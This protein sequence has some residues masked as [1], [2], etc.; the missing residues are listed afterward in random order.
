MIFGGTCELWSGGIRAGSRRRRRQAVTVQAVSLKF[1]DSTALFL[2]FLEGEE[3]KRRK[4][5][6]G[7]A[8]CRSGRGGPQEGP[9][10]QRP[11]DLKGSCLDLCLSP[12]LT[13]RRGGGGS[14][15]AFRRA[16]KGEAKGR[17]NDGV[18]V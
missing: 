16:R 14:L 11:A 3:G 4:L 2:D 13:R 10:A 17:W 5:K 1:A 8:E 12:N 15:R 18:M 7:P 6:G 9:E